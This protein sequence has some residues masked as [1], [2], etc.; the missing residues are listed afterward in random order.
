MYLNLIHPHSY[1]QVHFMLK[2]DITTDLSDHPDIEHKWSNIQV[3]IF[4]RRW[5]YIKNNFHP[6]FIKMQNNPKSFM[7]FQNLLK[8]F[9]MV[10]KILLVQSWT[11]KPNIERQKKLSPKCFFLFLKIIQVSSFEACKMIQSP[12][13]LNSLR[14]E[15]PNMKKLCIRLIFLFPY[16]ATTVASFII[17]LFY[18]FS[19]KDSHNYSSF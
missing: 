15:K 13:N 11:M 7:Y 12:P 5:S 17:S 19:I 14:C 2:H 6:P 9:P 1:V 16:L 8:M 18:F 3:Y 10:A 4:T